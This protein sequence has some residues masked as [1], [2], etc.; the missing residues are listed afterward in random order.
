MNNQSQRPPFAHHSSGAVL[1]VLILLLAAA[2]AALLLLP[3]EGQ[4][5]R[6][7][8]REQLA[9]RGWPSAW[10][11]ESKTEPAPAVEPELAAVAQP[12]PQPPSAWRIYVSP[13]APSSVYLAADEL[14]HYWEKSTGVKPEIIH[15]PEPGP[16]IVLGQSSLS[17]DQT[18]E[19]LPPESYRIVTRDGNLYIYGADTA[20]GERTAE[21]GFSYGTLYGVY[22]FLESE[23]GVRWLMPGEVG[24]VVPRHENFVL[25]SVDRTGAPA[26]EN[27]D[28]PYMGVKDSEEV[29]RWHLRQRSGSETHTERYGVRGEF[30]PGAGT[31][32]LNPGFSMSKRHDHSWHRLVPPSFYEKHPEWFAEHNGVRTR[33]EGTYYKLCT[34]NPEVVDYFAERAI[35]LFTDAPHATMFSLSPNDAEGWCECEECRKLDEITPDGERRI[36]RRILTFYNQVAERVAAKFPDKYVSG[37]VY[38]NFEKLPLDENFQLHPNVFL[39]WAPL[40]NYGYTHFREDQRRNWD[41]MLEGWSRM[42]RNLMYYDLLNVVQQPGVVAPLPVGRENLKRTLPALRQHGVRA[43]YLFGDQA[44]GVSAPLNYTLTRLAWNPDQDIDALVEE[45]YRQAYGKGGDAMLRMNDLLGERMAALY[46][47][48]PQLGY[49]LTDAHY[50]QVY[51][52]AWGEMETLYREAEAA[53]EDGP[54]KQRLELFRANMIAVARLLKGLGLIELT[55]TSPFYLSDADYPGWAASWK[56]SIY[57]RIPASADRSEE[58]RELA[59]K[60]P[61]FTEDSAADHPANVTDGK[62]L[63]LRHSQHLIFRSDTEEEIRL[64]VKPRAACASPVA[65]TVFNSSGQ[66]ITSGELPGP[67]TISFLAAGRDI[68]HVL[69]STRSIFSLEIPDVPHAINAGYRPKHGVHMF[70]QTRPLSFHVPAGVKQFEVAMSA[71]RPGYGAVVDVFDPRGRKVAELRADE[72]HVVSQQIPNE[73]GEAG[74]WMISAPRAVEGRHFFDVQIRFGEELDGYATFGAGRMLRAG[75]TTDTPDT[76]AN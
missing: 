3:G 70:A 64:R 35:K 28:L 1:W 54:Q 4:T 60:S 10:L 58:A 15:V 52:P 42:G 21:S 75:K 63:Q 6:D 36:T 61:A 19:E 26:F 16:L 24:E 5:P 27:R 38:Q 74:I 43:V 12:S 31:V 14:Q 68:Y 25:G 47:E 44:W 11:G 7:Y 37:Y 56:G 8:L 73:S 62:K 72:T 55:E 30:K 76:A 20:D 46:R 53:V 66:V 34:S 39:A 13:E 23:L 48:N 59:A 9:Q 22:D 45:F 40:S 65:Y 49:R 50:R 29:R 18:G 17:P 41:E 57:V 33:P 32:D 67:G 71:F 2:A 51:A 69:F